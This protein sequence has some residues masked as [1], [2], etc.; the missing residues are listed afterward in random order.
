MPSSG[1]FLYFLP[2]VIVDDV[3]RDSLQASPIGDVLSDVLVN[4]RSYQQHVVKLFVN[5][6]PTGSS[7]TL[8]VA[9]PLAWPDAHKIGF[10]SSEQTW[11][12]CDGYWLGYHNTIQPGPDS[13]ERSHFI[14]GYE[15]ELG[16]GN[17]WIAPVIRYPGGSPNLP[18]SMTRHRGK[19]EK[20]VLPQFS[21]AWDMAQWIWDAILPGGPSVTDE[22]YFEIACQCLGVN[23]RIGCEEASA[24][25]LFDSKTTVQVIH[26]AVDVPRI[27]A[28][29]QDD[30]KKNQ[31]TPEV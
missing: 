20:S 9:T 26:A 24:L 1:L 2:E 25:K 8:I 31:V 5:V 28:Y 19:F 3:S 18:C 16:D 10:Y 15:H 13:L 29:L 6:G 14:D 22:K 12:E 4:E 17:V 21:S 11:I 30:S 27:E 7:G 23:Y